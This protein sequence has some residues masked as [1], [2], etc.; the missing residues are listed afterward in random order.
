MRAFSGKRGLMRVQLWLFAVLVIAVAG[1]SAWLSTRYRFEIDLTATGRHTLSAASRDVLDVLA[2]PVVV[3]AYA[4]PDPGLRARIRNLVEP[5]QRRKPDVE[6]RF[7]DPDT[8]PDLVREQGVSTA[9]ELVI[10]YAERREHVQQLTEQA[11]TNALV[12]VGRGGE[13]YVAFVEGHGERSPFGEANFDVGEWAQHLQSRGFK[14]QNVNLAQQSGVPDNTTVLVIASPQVSYLPG[15]V[16]AIG[17]FIARGGNL[18]WLLEPGDLHGLASLAATL[19][20]E[21]VGG[22]IVDPATQLFGIDQPAFVVVTGY[23]AIDPV[24]DFGYPTVFPLASGL[25]HG[26]GG[27]WTQETILSTGDGAWS[28]T[29]ELAGNVGYDEE[30]DFPGPLAIGVTIARSRSGPGGDAR[31][32]VVVI[33][34]GDFLAN[35]YLGNGGNLDLGLR[36]VNWLASDEHLVDVPARTAP[37][38]NLE[39][40]PATGIGLAVWFLFGCPVLLAGIGVAVWRRRRHA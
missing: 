16:A 32:R 35:S 22:T 8:V 39:L 10:T 19:G 9:G 28:E 30:S 18:L 26:Q 21:P 36:L 27:E 33:G 4:G 15:E 12:A 13:R 1:L 3:T 23:P 24:R 17:D 11:L 5:Y 31:Q 25:G 7:L 37:D 40:S 38:L 34:D 20:I 29:G 14:V 6:L 2:G